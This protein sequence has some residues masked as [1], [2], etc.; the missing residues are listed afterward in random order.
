MRDVG[1]LILLHCTT[2]LLYIYNAGCWPDE[3]GRAPHPAWCNK[4]S[5]YLYQPKYAG[6]YCSLGEGELTGSTVYIM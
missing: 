5:C 3:G 6:F 2:H 1:S 4:S